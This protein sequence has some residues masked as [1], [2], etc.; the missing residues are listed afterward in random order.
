MQEKRR[1]DDEKMMM[2]P[3]YVQNKYFSAS[4]NF[5]GQKVDTLNVS[6]NFTG[7]SW[8]IKEE[9]PMPP[10]MPMSPDLELE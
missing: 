5:G 3:P 10:P 4:F 6:V 7:E 2:P 1:A 9:P 8:G